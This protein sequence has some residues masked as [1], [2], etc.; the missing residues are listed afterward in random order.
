M[1]VVILLTCRKHLHDR[2]M[3]MW[4][5][6]SVCARLYLVCRTMRMW[7]IIS[8]C[9]RVYLVCRTMGMWVIISVCARLYLA[10]LCFYDCA[11]EFCW[12]TCN[13]ESYKEYEKKLYIEMLLKWITIKFKTEFESVQLVYYHCIHFLSCIGMRKTHYIISAN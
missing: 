9:A 4:V 5:I 2:T 3:G 11:I 8:V 6:I 10:C 1:K 13:I 12:K 7:V